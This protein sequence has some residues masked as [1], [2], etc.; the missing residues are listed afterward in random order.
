M[1]ALPVN[2]GGG[3][4]GA[5]RPCVEEAAGIGLGSVC[6]VTKRTNCPSDWY[7]WGLA[8]DIAAQGTETCLGRIY[9]ASQED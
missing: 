9:G 5:A 4:V 6:Q 7:R 8:R 3:R 2:P 1:T